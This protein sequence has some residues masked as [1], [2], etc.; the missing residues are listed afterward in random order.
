MGRFFGSSQTSDEFFFSFDSSI[1]KELSEI[2]HGFDTVS[3][4]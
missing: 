1:V 3:F 4:R 2:V